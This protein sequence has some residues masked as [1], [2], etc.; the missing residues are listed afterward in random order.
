MTL[1]A[2]LTEPFASVGRLAT[3]LQQGIPEPEFWPAFETAMGSAF[4]HKLFTVLAFDA[5]KSLMR[6]LYSNRE[7]V[8]P[9]GGAKRVTDSPWTQ[10]VLR[11][12]KL[13]MGSQREDIKIYSEYELLWSIGCESFLNIP[14]RKN[15]VTVGTINLLD[16][17]GRYDGCSI[18]AALTFAQFGSD[19]LSQYLATAPDGPADDAQLEHV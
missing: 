2:P 4:G 15:G 7:D 1:I 13:M 14:V 9:T 10:H 3:L 5:D 12:G 18:E 19:K 16:R 17:A 6:R 11:E 8:S